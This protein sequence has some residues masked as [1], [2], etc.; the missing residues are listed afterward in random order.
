[1]FA[2]EEHTAALLYSA[3][4]ATL[5]NLE[6]IAGRPLPV[7]W[8][9][10]GAAPISTKGLGFALLAD[11]DRQAASSNAVASIERTVQTAVDRDGKERLDS[12]RLALCRAVQTH[13]LPP[14]SAAREPIVEPVDPSEWLLLSSCRAP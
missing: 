14:E 8:E 5:S 4:R 13:Q 1:M 2:I 9:R 10:M 11:V 7:G 12:S 3:D 6:R